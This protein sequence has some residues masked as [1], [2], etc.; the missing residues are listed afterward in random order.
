MTQSRGH[1]VWHELLT[2]NKQSATAFYPRVVSWKTQAWE[3]APSYTL[4]RGP[5][6]ALGGLG[7]TPL[8]REAADAPTGW[9]PFIGVSDVDESLDRALRL[10]ARVLTEPSQTAAGGKWAT[11][12]DPQGAVFAIYASAGGENDAA[13]A[14]EP[15]TG[16]FSWHELGTRDYKEAL[17]FYSE[18]FG[19]KLDQVHDMGPIGDYAL[20]AVGGRQIGGMYNIADKGSSEAHSPSWMCYIKVD[21]ADAAVEAA[22]AAGGTVLMGPMEVPGGSRIATMLDPDGMRFAVHAMPRKAQATSTAA[23]KPKPKARSAA[24]V[25]AA[26]RAPAKSPTRKAST[27]KRGKPARAA[28]AKR[29][30]SRP[31]AARLAAARR[32]TAKRPKAKR[33]PVKT[34]KRALARPAAKRPAS[35]RSVSRRPAGR[36][37]SGARGRRGLR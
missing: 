28:A 29:K 26:A 19:W 9:L 12:A 35:R 2:P 22:T 7:T 31:G 15:A 25:H 30:A 8:G 27:R 5:S 37:R 13:S 32:A 33:R 14:A 6:G 24:P 3:K 11:L 4:W 16:D 1:F 20:F 36:A 10:G 34:A 21:D 18:L 23:R 17:K